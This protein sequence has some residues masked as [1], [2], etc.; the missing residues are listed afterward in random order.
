M[1]SIIA[2]EKIWSRGA[3]PQGC[4]SNPTH[5][6]SQSSP[7]CSQEGHTPFP[8]TTNSFP[9]VSHFSPILKKDE[10]PL[11]RLTGSKRFKL[12]YAGNFG[13]SLLPLASPSSPLTLPTTGLQP[14]NLGLIR[15][16]AHIYTSQLSWVLPGIIPVHRS[17]TQGIQAAGRDDPSIF[18]G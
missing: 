10:T 18:L 8:S 11:L 3:K 1:L 2:E 17:D 9:A 4:S 5:L 15:I 13:L 14:S 6:S 12:K 16:L 7:Q